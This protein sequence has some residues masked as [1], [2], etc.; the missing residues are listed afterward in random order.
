MSLTA[1]EPAPILMGEGHTSESTEIAIRVSVTRSINNVDTREFVMLL[2]RIGFRIV[3][4][5]RAKTF[6][7]T[8]PFPKLPVQALLTVDG[9]HRLHDQILKLEQTSR[10]LTSWRFVETDADPLTGK[11]DIPGS[12]SEHKVHPMRECQSLLAEWQSEISFTIKVPNDVTPT[13]CSAT[14]SRQYSLIILLKATGV[15]VDDF[16]LEVP[17]QFVSAPIHSSLTDLSEP[18]D[19]FS[20]V[21]EENTRPLQCYQNMFEMVSENDN[22]PPPKYM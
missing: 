10:P 3:P 16:V 18:V 13:F 6:Y 7:S 21:S 11:C 9:P 14:A 20:E 17:V 22:E 4:G 1:A 2:Q 5:L 15:H 8:Q 12:T 19:C